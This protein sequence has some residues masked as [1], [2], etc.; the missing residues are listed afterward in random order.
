MTDMIYLFEEDDEKMPF[1][2]EEHSESEESDFSS[3]VGEGMRFLQEDMGVASIKEENVAESVY[4]AEKVA[5]NHVFYEMNTFGDTYER[6]YAEHRMSFFDVEN[7]SNV[8]AEFLKNEVYGGDV[9]KAEV[10]ESS[11]IGRASEKTGD[12]NISVTVN[13]NVSVTKECDIDDVIERLSAKIA[14]AV[15]AAG[16]GMH[17]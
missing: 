10:F 11:G 4:G 12:K 1:V 14:E 8:K 9:L 15:E 2:F 17:V 5:E 16:E 7:G 6:S 3:G 13:N